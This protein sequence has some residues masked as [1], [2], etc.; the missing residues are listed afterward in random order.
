MPTLS[1]FHVPGLE[2]QLIGR[3][4]GEHDER[5]AFPQFLTAGFTNRDP[6]PERNSF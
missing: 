6:F 4:E 5:S 3:P 1:A 2:G